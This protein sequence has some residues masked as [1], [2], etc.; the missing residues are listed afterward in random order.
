MPLRHRRR[1]CG[2]GFARDEVVRG[3]RFICCIARSPPP[4]RF[5]TTQARRRVSSLVSA[6]VILSGPAGRPIRFAMET[7]T[8]IARLTTNQSTALRGI[9]QNTEAIS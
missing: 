4:E 9:F 3:Y 6:T 2:N 8:G 7:E 1:R 5:S